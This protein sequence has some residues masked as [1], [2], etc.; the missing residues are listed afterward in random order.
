MADTREE[1]I[2][3]YGKGMQKDFASFFGPFG[4]LEV[5]RKK[6]DDKYKPIS[7]EKGDFKR[8]NDV[9]MALLGTP[10]DV[11]RGIQRMLD[12]MPDLEWFGLFMQGQQ[13]VLPLDTVKRNLEMF[14]TKVIPECQD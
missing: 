1:A 5:L 10:D 6:D 2:A 11:K 4:Y 8:M 9:E 14:A 7:A 3:T 12:R 13:G